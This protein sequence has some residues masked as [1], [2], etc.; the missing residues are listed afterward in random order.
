MWED[1]QR[2]KG[3]WN[4][5]L[6]GRCW[7]RR[8]SY[9]SLGFQRSTSFTEWLTESLC[10]V[11]YCAQ[12]QWWLKEAPCPFGANSLVRDKQTSRQFQD[13][14]IGAV[15]QENSIIGASQSH[16]MCPETGFH[17]FTQNWL[18]RQ[19]MENIKKGNMWTIPMAE[20]LKFCALHFSSP[21]FA[22]SDPWCRPTPLISHAVEASHIQNRGRLAQMLAQGPSSSQK[23]EEEHTLRAKTELY[24]PNSLDH[25]G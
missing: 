5:R 20:W 23:K 17:Q 16:S 6:Q 21:G 13:G 25:K 9:P 3:C 10:C 15:S 8:P 22:G 1:F 18:G 4:Q 14:M 19:E 12:I 2:H 24:I 7:R 11:R